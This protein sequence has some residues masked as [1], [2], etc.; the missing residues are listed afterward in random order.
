MNSFIS[1]IRWL[2]SP[3]EK[4]VFLLLTILM[5][6]SALLETFGIG[7]LLGAAALFLAPQNQFAVY[8]GKILNSLMTAY[9]AN[10]KIALC[11][12]FTAL[13]LAAK[14]VFAL[15]IVALQT[16]FITNKQK[17]IV[18]RLITTFLHADFLK[19]SAYSSDE[20]NGMINRVK[21]MCVLIFLP[22]MQMLADI[23][24]ITVLGVT[25]F[26]L[27]PAI[28]ALGICAMLIFTLT[29][30]FFTR[31]YNA[32]LGKNFL[33]TDIKENKIRL[34]IL[35]GVK[36][37]KCCA[38]EDVFIRE[39]SNY[40]RQSTDLLKKMF[41]VGQIPRLSLESISFIL[42]AGIF[43]L[44]L[45]R[46]TPHA[47]IL[48]T[49]TVLIAAVARILPALSRCHYNFTQIKQNYPAME[50]IIN[51]LKNTPQENSFSGSGADAAGT[52]EI[53]NISF[54]YDK[55][56]KILDNFSLTIPPRSS[57]GIAGKSGKGKTTLADLLT[58]L[59]IPDSGTIT[60]GNKN[61][62]S[63][64]RNWRK[65]IGYVTQN[66][67][68]FE[69]TLRDN[70]IM[71]E[72]EEKTDN[73][74][75]SAA[76][77]Q[78]QLSDFSLETFVSNSNLSGGQRQRIGIARALYQNAKLL[79]LD[80]ATSALDNDTES[81]FCEVLKTLKGNVTLIVI[82]HRESTLNLCDKIIKM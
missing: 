4:R 43:S 20:C 42:A 25:T 75:V 70:I 45:L 22:G 82:S 52:I 35:L 58:T 72:P 18:Q 10:F 80:E 57:I 9:P 50:H 23:L 78:A 64:P 73:E 29:I 60:C 13:L 68:I 53:D 8:A 61:I 76:L 38:K 32:F 81:A 5:A 31:K 6:L 79:I 59:L 62:F 49:F 41:I 3:H 2:F 30:A 67:F 69:G 37:V 65:Q 17:D 12:I 55:K 27:F 40:Y 77:N 24:A 54:S 26:C 56:N 15:F 21:D 7:L 39:H 47:E 14:N 63:N 74:K 51:F 34:N 1:G 44:L 11:V 16:N 46:N 19:I 48:I 66:T 28:T 71:G 33:H 36:T